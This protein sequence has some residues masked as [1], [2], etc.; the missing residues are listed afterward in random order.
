MVANNRNLGHA[1]PRAFINKVDNVFTI[2]G[3]LGLRI[4]LYAEITFRL[5]VRDKIL[6]ALLK[7]FRI[8]PG[9]LIKRK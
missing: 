9:L 8:K 1:V 7:D 2:L 5:K 6:T 4:D 3:R